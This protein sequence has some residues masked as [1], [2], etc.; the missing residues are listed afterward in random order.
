MI[1][2]FRFKPANTFQESFS[3]QKKMYIPPNLSNLMLTIYRCS[4]EF[5]K[6]EFE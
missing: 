3:I 6:S 2:E 1:D 5:Q 4:K